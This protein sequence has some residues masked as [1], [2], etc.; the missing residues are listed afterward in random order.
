MM[1]AAVAGVACRVRRRPSRLAYLGLPIVAFLASSSAALGATGALTPAGC[2][3]DPISNTDGCGQT[4]P[5]LGGAYSVALSADGTSVY[6]A[7]FNDNAIVRFDRD[8]T[9]GALTPSG[10]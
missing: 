5:G 10:C 6:V 3:A 9:T 8:T 7:A 1:R 2:I 4:T